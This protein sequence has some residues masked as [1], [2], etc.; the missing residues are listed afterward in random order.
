M[1]IW[2]WLN[3]L[4]YL[5]IQFFNF[6]IVFGCTKINMLADNSYGTA[7]SDKCKKTN[8]V[9]KFPWEFQFSRQD[10]FTQGSQGDIQIANGWALGEHQKI[11]SK[12]TLLGTRIL[13]NALPKC[14]PWS[15]KLGTENSCSE[16]PKE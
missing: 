3:Y 4:T 14:K 10:K 7:H 15:Q 1:I 5:D 9:K 16:I 6:Q 2:S 11:V 13:L 12:D 8:V